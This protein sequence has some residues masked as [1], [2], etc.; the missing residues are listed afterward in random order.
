MTEIRAYAAAMELQPTT[1]VQNSGCGG[2]STWPKWE[3]GG[4]CTLKTAEKIRKYMADNPPAA[5]E[6]REAS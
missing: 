4:A 3:A 5:A 2:G 1:V 6:I